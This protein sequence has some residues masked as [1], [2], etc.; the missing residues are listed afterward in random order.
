MSSYIILMSGHESV[1]FLES[2]EVIKLT[3][4]VEANTRKQR[5]PRRRPSL[6]GTAVFGVRVSKRRCR[7]GSAEP[8]TCQLSVTWDVPRS[9]S[10][11]LEP[12]VLEAKPH[13]GSSQEPGGRTSSLTGRLVPC[14]RSRTHSTH[15]RCPVLSERGDGGKQGE[16]EPC[17]HGAAPRR[18]QRTPTSK[19]VSSDVEGGRAL[20]ETR[21]GEGTAEGTALSEIRWPSLRRE[22]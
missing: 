22:S 10:S 7:S 11:P 20:A 19:Q 4:N 6:P 21:R 1:L 17:T 8:S 3:L 16:P 2:E 15:T 5:N 13:A 9:T 18:G 12:L 14:T